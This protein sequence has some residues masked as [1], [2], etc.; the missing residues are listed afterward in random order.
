MSYTI[1]RVIEWDGRRGT[2]V[3]LYSTHQRFVSAQVPNS[4]LPGI[5][6]GEMVMIYNDGLVELATSSFLRW[7]E[8]LEI[9]L[10]R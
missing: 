10:S 4:D 9:T 5:K 3:T 2:V 8:E 7:R 6:L 1:A